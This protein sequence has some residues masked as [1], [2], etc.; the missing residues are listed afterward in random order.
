MLSALTRASQ[1]DVDP[2]ALAV[3]A[4]KRGTDSRPKGVMLSH[5]NIVNSLQS[6]LGLLN[7]RP[8]DTGCY[9][10]PFYQTEIVNALG[11]LM[12][13]GKVVVNR[14]V[15]AAEVL[16]LLQDEKCTHINMVPTLYDWLQQHP[17]FERYNLASL[18]LLTYSGSAFPPDKLTQCVKS[19]WKRFAQ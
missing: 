9:V 5:R 8:T 3:L 13:G 4:Y 12:A 16:R 14:K 7:L 11:M 15:D 10:L 2:N 19:F 1:V 6:I 18:K 17:R